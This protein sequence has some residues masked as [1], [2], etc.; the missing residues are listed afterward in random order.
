MY[1]L[2]WMVLI[3]DWMLLNV[4]IYF[5]QLGINITILFEKLI[6]SHSENSEDEEEDQQC[7][8]SDWTGGDFEKSVY[9]VKED[10]Q[11][12]SRVAY[13]TSLYETRWERH[14][15][16]HLSGLNDFTTR[17]EKDC[18]ISL[19]SQVWCI[20]TYFFITRIGIMNAMAFY[21]CLLHCLNH[22]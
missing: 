4:D 5:W 14:Q 15:H 19:P 22:H 13:R 12:T 2:L 7:P 1:D 10:D 9:P 11:R 3:N 6:G 8:A 20:C 16:L 17:K 18:K 21:S